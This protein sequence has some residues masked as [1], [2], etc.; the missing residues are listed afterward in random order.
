MFENKINF[1]KSPSLFENSS[2]S[3]TKFFIIN[4]FIENDKICNICGSSFTNK[5]NKKRH[6][7]DIHKK[8]YNEI[9]NMTDKQSETASSLETSKLAVNQMDVDKAEID[10]MT[11]EYDA[12]RSRLNNRLVVDG[13]TVFA[14]KEI[15]NLLQQIGSTIPKEVKIVTL[16]NTQGRHFVIEARAIKYQQLGYFK[17]L[18]RINNILTNVQASTGIRFID[19]DTNE[20][21]VL[22]TIEGDLPEQF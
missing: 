3:N 21:Y 12:M 9:T 8:I 22:I 17:S 7:R 15:T 13:E 14:E 10:Y 18:L 2:I 11:A 16:E 4:N 20:E 5:F 6:I 19:S 1:N